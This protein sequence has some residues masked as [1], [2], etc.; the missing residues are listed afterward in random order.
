MN[1]RE[2]QFFIAELAGMMVASLI[3]AFI[4]CGILYA[5][6]DK[7]GKTK[8]EKK[9]MFFAPFV[10][11]ALIVFVINYALAIIRSGGF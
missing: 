9:K 10:P 5:F 4:V 3:L 6:K 11:T 8:A 1:Q 7:K 2:T